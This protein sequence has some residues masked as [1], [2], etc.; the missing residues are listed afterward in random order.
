MTVWSW[1]TKDV[2]GY[3]KIFETFTEETGIEVEFKAHVNTE[4]DTI[5]ETA[6]KAR[7]GSRCHA[8]ASVRHLAAPGRRRLPRAAGW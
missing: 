6:L 2:A 5:L 3:E 4:Y 7:K 8:A 1:R